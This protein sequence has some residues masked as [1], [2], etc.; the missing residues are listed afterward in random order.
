MSQTEVDAFEHDLAKIM[1][2]IRRDVFANN[3]SAERQ[4]QSSFLFPPLAKI[5]NLLKT[6]LCV[7]QL[8]FM[9]N[10]ARLRL[11]PVHGLEDLI[12][13]S[14]DI[15]EIAEIKLQRQI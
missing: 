14:N 2:N 5:D 11:S 7:G 3:V 15:F 8:A 12:K 10:Q 9:N 4:W 1:S 6:G 13:R